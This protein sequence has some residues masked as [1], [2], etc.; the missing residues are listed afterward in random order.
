MSGVQMQHRAATAA[1]ATAMAAAVITVV[2]GCGGPNPTPPA[3]STAAPTAP[4]KAIPPIAATVASAPPPVTP[5]ST[6]S[7]DRFLPRFTDVLLRSEDPAGSGPQIALRFLRALQA[8]KYLHAAQQLSAGERITIALGSESRLQ[9]VMT[10][11]VGNAELAKAGL[12][13]DAGPVN[14][15][16]AVV[17]CGWLRV[18][19]HVRTGFMPGVQIN[20]YFPHDDVFLGPHSHAFTNYVI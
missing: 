20:S 18:V 2:T 7:R 5:R 3:G 17:T 6:S 11:V 16:A 13:T 9:R 8:G 10:D 1:L 4:T 19:V 14:E 12:C 15:E